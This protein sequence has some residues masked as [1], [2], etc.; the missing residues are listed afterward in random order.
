MRYVSIYFTTASKK[1]QLTP[2]MFKF[3]TICFLLIN[4]V[5]ISI[6]NK[7]M[8]N[9]MQHGRKFHESRY[10]C[11]GKYRFRY[12]K[13]RVHVLQNKW[14]VLAKKQNESAPYERVGENTPKQ[15]CWTI[16]RAMVH[17]AIWKIRFIGEWC[18]ST[19]CAMFPFR[20]IN[21]SRNFAS[22]PSTNAKLNEMHFMI[23]H[24]VDCVISKNYC[25]AGT[26]KRDATSC[27]PSK[28]RFKDNLIYAN[29]W[30]I[31]QNPSK[32]IASR[33][34]S[35]LMKRADAITGNQILSK[36]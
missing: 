18:S 29:R 2:T 17:G 9:R 33:F 23:M 14:T 32:Y 16:R 8:K 10:F 28:T 26:K 36:K 24:L 20:S 27:E 13:F 1:F 30:N 22:Q 15:R 5:F 25:S 21:L 3:Y 7:S 34:T 19:K 35:Y 12:V 31:S 4:L 6:A 11:R